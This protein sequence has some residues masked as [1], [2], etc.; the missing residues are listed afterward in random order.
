MEALAQRIPPTNERGLAGFDAAFNFL[1][2]LTAI[3]TSSA[4]S[5]FINDQPP[6]LNPFSAS[7]KPLKQVDNRK[8]TLTKYRM[9]YDHYRDTKIISRGWVCKRGNNETKH[10]GN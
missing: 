7:L 1:E 4:P 3:M 5:P 10:T 9:H 2:K 6:S 8:D